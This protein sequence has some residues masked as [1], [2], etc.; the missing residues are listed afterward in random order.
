MLF[1][2]LAVEASGLPVGFVTSIKT[3][4]SGVSDEPFPPTLREVHCIKRR[5][6]AVAAVIGIAPANFRQAP[7]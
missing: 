3:K 7:A 5:K 2:F 6:K 4:R 1:L